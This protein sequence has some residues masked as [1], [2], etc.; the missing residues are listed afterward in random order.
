MQFLRTLFWVILAVLAVIFSFN[1]W[2]VVTVRLW[3]DIVIDTRLPV[4]LFAVFAMGLV[5]PWIVHRIT[6]WSLR[7]KL[8]TAN[9]NLVE[10]RAT[11]DVVPVAGNSAPPGVA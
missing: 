1:N 7:R 2:T 8:E 10:T 9:R 5:P 4:L 11:G 3:S 6:R